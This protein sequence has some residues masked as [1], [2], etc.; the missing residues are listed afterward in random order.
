[1]SLAYSRPI[2]TKFSHRWK[3]SQSGSFINVDLSTV[4]ISEAASNALKVCI[5]GCCFLSTFHAEEL[6]STLM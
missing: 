2:V 3:L 1:M 5:Y 6:K 4:S